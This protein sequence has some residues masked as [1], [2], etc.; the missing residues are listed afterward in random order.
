MCA[1]KEADGKLDLI[2]IGHQRIR[3]GIAGFIWM[4]APK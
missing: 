2:L 1:I 3:H 4:L